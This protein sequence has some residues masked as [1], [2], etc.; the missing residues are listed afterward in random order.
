MSV[1]PLYD[2]LIKHIPKKDLTIKQKQKIISDISNIDDNTKELIYVLIQF[3]YKNN[4]KINDELPYNGEKTEVSNRLY[5]VSWNLVDLP[6]P[7]RQILYKFIS[8]HMKQKEED[9]KRD[10]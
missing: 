10:V 3:Y 8:L 7:L 4:D 1:F 6:I 2:N 9:I 5:D